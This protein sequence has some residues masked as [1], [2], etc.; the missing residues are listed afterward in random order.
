MVSDVSILEHFVG[1]LWHGSQNLES[2]IA[3]PHDGISEGCKS[4]HAWML[5]V[6]FS[7]D[8]QEFSLNAR[9]VQMRKVACLSDFKDISLESA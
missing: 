8:A 1:Q 2:D 6:S 3:S 9:C 7:I 4:C 5:T